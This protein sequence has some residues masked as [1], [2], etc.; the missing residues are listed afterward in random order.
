[1]EPAPLISLKRALEQESLLF[2]LSVRLLPLQFVGVRAPYAPCLKQL[3]SEL[4]FEVPAL[5]PSEMRP[6]KVG[7]GIAGGAPHRFTQREAPICSPAPIGFDWF[8]R[9]YNALI[10]QPCKS[11]YSALHPQPFNRPAYFNIKTWIL[12]IWFE[13]YTRYLANTIVG[14]RMKG[15]E[16]Y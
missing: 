14:P 8:P 15:D 12:D 9:P 11:S 1:L 3:E 2:N 16:R 5:I 10:N 4:H 13:K 7:V 6:P